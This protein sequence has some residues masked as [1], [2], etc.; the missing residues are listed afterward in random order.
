MN[1]L[2]KKMTAILLAIIMCTGMILPTQVIAAE[3]NKPDMIFSLQNES[4]LIEFSLSLKSMSEEELQ[5]VIELAQ[6]ESENRSVVNIVTLKSAW[7]AAAQIAR[8]K[9][10]P[11]AATLVENSVFYKNYS[12]TNGKFSKAIKGTRAYKRMLNKKRGSD[13]FSKNDHSDLFYAINKFSFTSSSS[14]KGKRFRISD[15]FDFALDMS[16]DNLFVS[17][18]N[19]WAYLNQNIWVLHPIQVSITLDS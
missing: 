17:L 7:L 6:I 13:A 16:Y 14:S 12:E 11:L 3:Q 19:N 15:K 4:D 10:Y 9:G 5:Q 1:A 2:L 8:V 18:V